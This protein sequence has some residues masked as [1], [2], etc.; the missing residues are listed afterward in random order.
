MDYYYPRVDA[1]L[2]NGTPTAGADCS[3]MTI[4]GLVRWATWGQLVPSVA[5]IR[6]KVGT[7]T[8]GISM[9]QALQAYKAYGVAATLTRAFTDITAGLQAGKAVHAAIGYG[10]VN[11]NA[12][13][14][15]GDPNFSGGH[16]LGLYGWE[17]IAGHSWVLWLDPL[18]DG[19]RAGIAKQICMAKQGQ[20][21]GAMAAFSSGVTGIVV[22][23]GPPPASAADRLK[24][25][26]A[27]FDAVMVEAQ[28][29][30]AA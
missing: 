1:Q 24:A 15:S 12:P 28:K 19:R 5:N 23:Q 18:G 29:G 8:G 20:V 25:K 3:V 11:Q 2:Q 30:K 21:A 22:T 10:W 17:A 4:Q 6:A 26:D 9:S 27:A 13:Q 16:G 7:P 14:L